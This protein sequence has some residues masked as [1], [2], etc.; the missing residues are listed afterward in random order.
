[1]IAGTGEGPPLAQLLLGR[2]WRVRVS[3]VTPA[4]RLSYPEDPRLEVVVGALAGVAAWREALEAARRQGD[5]FQWL[6]DASHPFATHVSAAAA[7]AC[8]DRA[9][10]LLRLHRPGLAAPGATPLHHLSQLGDHLAIGE[11]LLLAI[12]ARH[13]GAAIGHSP[14]A[15]HHSRVLPHPLA[16]RTALRAGLPSHRLASLHP[17]PDGAVERALCHHWG[18]QTILCRQSGSRTEALWLR[19]SGELG[20]RLLLLRRPPEP[21]GGLT[22]PLAELVARI[23]WP[24]R[25]END[26]D[27]EAGGG[28]SGD[29]GQ[30]GASVTGGSGG[31]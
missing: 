2:G 31:G 11:R 28:G 3:V 14:Q 13:L 26:G 20:L 29:G 30:A 25:A 16:I 6:I 9:E 12:G 23:G 24:D 10:Q 1:L 19:I 17:T 5:P 7:A 15:C 27:A 21:A 22:L 4:A 18:I 8:A